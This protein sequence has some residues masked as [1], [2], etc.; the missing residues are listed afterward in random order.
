MS[1]FL[2]TFMNK[3]AYWNLGDLS[4]VTSKIIKRSKVNNRLPWYYFCGLV[5][6]LRRSIQLKAKKKLGVKMYSIFLNTYCY[7]T[8]IYSL[9]STELMYSRKE[10]ILVFLR[11]HGN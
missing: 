9:D 11:F 8:G 4:R 2:L 10:L 5:K 3:Y 1:L 7:H 6:P